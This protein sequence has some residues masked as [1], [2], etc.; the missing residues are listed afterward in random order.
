MFFWEKKGM[1]FKVSDIL[2]RPS[3]MWN[4]AQGI[5]SLDC[6]DYIRIYFCCREKP[7]N[8]GQ[9][10]SRICYLDVDKNEPQKII[11]IGKKPVLELGGLGEFDEFGTYPFSVVRNNGKV[12]GYYGGV[13]RCESVPFNVAIGVCVSE[14]NGVTFKK[15]GRGPVLSYSYDEPFVVCSPKVRIYNGQW[16]MFYSAGKK[17][18][19][20]EKRPE[21]CYKLRMAISDDGINWQK[22]HLD[23]MENKI[24]EMESQACGDV[25]YKNGKYHMFFCY[26]NHENFRDDPSNSY[27]IGYACSDDL[28]HWNRDDTKAGIDVDADINAWDHE[29]VA[30]P[31]LF[32][33]NNNIYMLYLGNGVGRDGFGIAKLNG[34]LV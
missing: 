9:T 13:T 22:K 10:V 4:Y 5:N 30:Y 14:D 28:C 8:L 29:M 20:G 12:Y 24:G 21:V 19:E 16:Y 27:R 11:D 2:D 15:I 34:E 18:T 23:I 6:G 31:H 7:N 33:S 26:R 3:W 17:W 32:M 1:I 25:F